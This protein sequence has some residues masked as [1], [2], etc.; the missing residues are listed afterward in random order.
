M[1]T[2]LMGAC[3]VH[4][5][6]PPSTWPIPITTSFPI[7]HKAEFDVHVGP[8]SAGID[9]TREPR[10]SER[11][12]RPWQVYRAA[13]FAELDV[14]RLSRFS[15]VLS[16]RVVGCVAETRIGLHLLPP[17]PWCDVSN[18]LSIREQK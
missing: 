3:L 18:G 1:P 4:A 11:G 17:R 8:A 13:I 7:R 6:V 2:C 14:S 15:Q 5:F 10:C 16:G 12:R 9:A